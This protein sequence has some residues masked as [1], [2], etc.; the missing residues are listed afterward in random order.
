MSADDLYV[1]DWDT[2]QTYRRDRGQPP[3]IKVHRCLM[4]DPKWVALT[5]A[6][7]GQLVSI[8]LLAAD[9]NGHIPSSPDLIKR[10]CFIEGKLDLEV[11][12]TLGLI[13]RRQDDANMVSGWRQRDA[14]EAEAETEAEKTLIGV[15]QLWEVWIEELG[16]ARPD[17]RLT[18]TRSKKLKALATEHLVGEDP[19]GRFRQILQAVKTSEH[20]MSKRE[21]QMPESLFRNEDRRDTWVNK[22]ANPSMNGNGSGPKARPTVPFGGTGRIEV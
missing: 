12:I 21:Y 2:W 22:A 16:G 20:H 11:F 8:W 6:Q 9:R 15:E 4:R 19:L 7:R 18:A 17:P 14:P 3:W 1:H 13:E 10:L 5:D